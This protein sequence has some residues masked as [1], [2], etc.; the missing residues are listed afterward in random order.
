MQDAARRKIKEGRLGELP[1]RIKITELLLEK[2]S[3]FVAR[4]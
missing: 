3:F 4:Y 1:L 2:S